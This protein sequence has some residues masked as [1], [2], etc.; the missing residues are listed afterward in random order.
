[1]AHVRGNSVEP[2][3]A[4]LFVTARHSFAL[5][6]LTTP[7]LWC[8]R[9]RLVAFSFVPGIKLNFMALAGVCG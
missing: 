9:L 8:S 7:S 2:L 6:D 4:T 5:H 1:M 3:T